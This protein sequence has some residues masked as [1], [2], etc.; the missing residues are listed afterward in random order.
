MFRSGYKRAEYLRKKRYFH[1]Q[2]RDCYFVPCNFGTEPHLLS[3]G[4]NV[5][6]TSNV[7]FVSHDTTA[8]MFRKMDPSGCYV[9]RVGKIE[10][11]S[12]VFVGAG[13]TILYDVK[14]GNNVIIAAGSLVNCDIPDGM[15][16]GGVPAK[17]IGSFDAYMQKSRELSAGLPWRDSDLFE[18]R[19]AAQIKW[20][21]EDQPA[22]PDEAEEYE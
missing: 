14:I 11:G 6:I 12:N 22:S 9:N 13:S 7:T 3:F 20:L 5:V 10:I 16:F 2:G 15:I 1:S 21:W 18:V 17:R 8:A 19:R 4:D